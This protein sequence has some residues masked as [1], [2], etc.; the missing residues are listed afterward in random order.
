MPPPT[1][2]LCIDVDDLPRATAFYTAALG[3][4]VGRRLGEAGVEL[5]GGSCPID[6]LLKPSGSL[7]FPHALRGRDYGRHWTPVHLDVVVDSVD[8]ATRRAVEAG[9]H[10]EQ[11]PA[12]TAW[13]RMALIADPW[14][15][16]L[17]LLSFRGA[18]YDA[19]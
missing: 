8:E 2:R 5:L 15:H 17:C 18:G 9:A 1:F 16:G 6:L 14:G 12:D 3:L 13:G 4:T 10:L 11:G 19:L 7:P